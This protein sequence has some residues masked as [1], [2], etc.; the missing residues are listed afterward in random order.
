VSPST[1][2]G[3]LGLTA[4]RRGGA[5]ARWRDGRQACG[6]T[7]LKP[8]DLML[9]FAGLALIE[10]VGKLHIEEPRCRRGVLVRWKCQVP[11]IWAPSARWVA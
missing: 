7:D 2:R 3:K 10:T 9:V 4:G 11:Q 1:R 8:S 6:T 5:R